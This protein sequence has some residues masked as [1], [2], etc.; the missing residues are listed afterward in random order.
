MT[1]TKRL[2]QAGLTSERSGIAPG[3]GLEMR[4]PG[5]GKWNND[6]RSTMP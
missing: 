6:E 4:N 5:Q 2:D 3:I 1:R